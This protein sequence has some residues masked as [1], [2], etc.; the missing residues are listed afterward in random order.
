MEEG[1]R[2]I[3]VEKEIEIISKFKIAGFNASATVSLVELLR[4]V[5]KERDRAVE[6]C[7]SFC[8]KSCGHEKRNQCKKWVMVELEAD[9]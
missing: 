1:E 3:E 7:I 9:K 8:G 2:M 5:G 4:Q 6:L